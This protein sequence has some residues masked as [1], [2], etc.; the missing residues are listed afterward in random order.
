MKRECIS[1]LKE[2]QIS[3]GVPWE[4][5]CL[6]FIQ[7]KLKFHVFYMID[8][9]KGSSIGTC[10]NTYIIHK[11]KAYNINIFYVEEGYV[12]YYENDIISHPSCNILS[13]RC[14]K[15]HTWRCYRV[16]HLL[17]SIA[18]FFLQINQGFSILY[19]YF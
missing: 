5:C 17:Q 4:I 8:V 13:V 16:K 15:Q 7:G 12:F 19:C 11:W 14:T 2:I 9:L 10:L 3:I 18:L 1:P 6:T